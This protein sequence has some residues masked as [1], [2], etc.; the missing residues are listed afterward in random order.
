MSHRLSVIVS[1]DI[2]L[3][4]R[5][6]DSSHFLI[7]PGKHISKFFEKVGVNIDFFRGTCSCDEDIFDNIGIPGDVH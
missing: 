5:W 2:V 6:I 7:R 4:Y 1:L 3:N